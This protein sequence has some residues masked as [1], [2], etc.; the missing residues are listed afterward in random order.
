[1]SNVQT[2]TSRGRIHRI[3]LQLWDTAG[4][5][6]FRSLTTAFYRDAMGFLLIF[7]MTNERSF[8]EVTNW[9]EQLRVHAYC[10]R[11]DVVLCAN[12]SDLEPLRVVSEQRA[13]DLA[14]KHGLVYVETSAST[15]QNV[16][17]AVDILVERVMDRWV[18]GVGERNVHGFVYGL[19]SSRAGCKIRFDALSCRADIVISTLAVMRIWDATRPRTNRKSDAIVERLT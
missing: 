6:R 18:F 13:R 5:E 2:H 8:V 15:G 16:A 11:P 12:K 3:H 10:E 4:Q 17:R 9:I 1:M 19:H 7:D 14:E